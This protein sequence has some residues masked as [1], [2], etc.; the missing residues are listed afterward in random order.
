ML[1]TNVSVKSENKEFDFGV[2]SQIALGEKG[3]GRR[4][5]ALTCPEGTELKGNSLDE[6]L[7]IGL[8]KS[9]KPR[10]IRKADNELYM[11]L[12]AEGGYTRRGNGTIKVLKDHVEDFEVLARGNGADG[13]AGRIGYWDVVLVRAPQNGIIRVRTSGAG[14]GTP[15]DLFV[16][17][18][19]KVYHC[20]LDTLGKCCEAID[21]ELP[22]V[23]TKDEYG[24]FAYNSEE[25]ATL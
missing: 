16:I 2:I 25:W 10:V 7:T 17:K 8:T 15:S 14:Y 3:R 5:L 9:G 19:G 11:V 23:P 18:D 24:D 1:Y 12:S 21:M 13:D 22:F 6:S 20:H 4:L